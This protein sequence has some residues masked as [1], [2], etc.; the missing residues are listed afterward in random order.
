M[1]MKNPFSLFKRSDIDLKGKWWH[2]LF[3][4]LYITLLLAV[5]GSASI[6]HFYNKEVV[7]EQSFNITVIKSWEDYISVQSGSFSEAQ[8]KQYNTY[9]ASGMSPEDAKR[10]AEQPS[11]SSFVRQHNDKVGCFTKDNGLYT[12]SEYTSDDTIAELCNGDSSIVA[13]QENWIYHLQGIISIILLVLFWSILIQFMYHKVF[14]FIL[15]G[16][17]KK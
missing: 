11:F 2:R 10:L 5:A 8:E 6:G 12:L 15:L 4:V 14:L 16:S 1:I 13:Y 17:N 3:V 7:P 9:R